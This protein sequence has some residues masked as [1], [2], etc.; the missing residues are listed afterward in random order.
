[1]FTI[2][3]N[4][5]AAL[6]S[7]VVMFGQ[8]FCG[9]NVIAYYSSDIFVQSGFTQV[10]ALASSLGFDALNWLFA[11]PAFFTAKEF[12]FVHVAIRLLIAGFSFWST[13]ETGCVTGVSIGIYLFA[14]FYSPGKG[15]G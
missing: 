11:I 5:N 4:R 3:R 14:I 8:Q 6:A 1:M 9:V 12:T 7:W 15:P 13:S 10:S 2:P